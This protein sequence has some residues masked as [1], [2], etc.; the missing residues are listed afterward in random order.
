MEE[1]GGRRTRTR[2]RR[3]RR[4]RRTRRTRRRMLRPQRCAVKRPHRH[5]APPPPQP[6]P[7]HLPPHRL[8]PRPPRHCHTT[9]AARR[10]LPAARKPLRRPCSPPAAA[11]AAVAAVAA[12]AAAAAAPPQRRPPCPAPAPWCSLRPRRLPQLPARLPHSPPPP[13][14]S[15]SRSGGS[16][17]RG[18]VS[19]PLRSCAPCTSCPGHADDE[20][21]EQPDEC[22]LSESSRAAR[23]ECRR[24]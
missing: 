14:S 1:G 12:A 13:S 19:F 21:P 6:P 20:V 11:A 9:A 17:S 10:L 23:R 4:M 5:P 7:H 18:C 15:S 16:S 24:V 3:T 22:F 8:P 2:T